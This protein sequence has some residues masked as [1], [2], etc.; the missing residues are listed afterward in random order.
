MSALFDG[1]VSLN[2]IVPDSEHAT[3]LA[4]LKVSVVPSVSSCLIPYVF[5]SST[6]PL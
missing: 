2:D 3:I 6:D 1:P 5:R 4:H